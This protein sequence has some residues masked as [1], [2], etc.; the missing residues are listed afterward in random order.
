MTPKPDHPISHGLN[1]AFKTYDEFYWNLTTQ[2]QGVKILATAPAGPP[3]NS[4]QPISAK[5][6]AVRHRG[7]KSAISSR[8]SKTSTTNSEAMAR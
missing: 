4:A 2:K 6:P 8:D 7:K 3:G 5:Q 1:S